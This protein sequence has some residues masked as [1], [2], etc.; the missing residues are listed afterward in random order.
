MKNT[1]KL[2][3]YSDV[4]EEYVA[5]EAITPGHLVELLS[6]GKVQKHDIAGGSVMPMFA[7][8]D[9]LQG[10][11]IDDAYAEDDRAQVWV[12]GRGDEVYA[13]LKDDENV[14]VGDFVESAGGGL[15]QKHVADDESANPSD[16][17]SFTMYDRQ[18]VGV[19]TEAVDLSSS[20]GT[21]PDTGFRVKVKII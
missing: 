19:V 12:P 4:I 11:G 1:I 3:K 10:N 14:A 16:S 20:S 8:E 2:K 13:L 18:I 5:H 17:L 21:Y 7:L 9:E 15:L 6:T